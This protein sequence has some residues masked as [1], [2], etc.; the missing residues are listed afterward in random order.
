MA[1]ARP[2]FVDI[3]ERSFTMDVGQLEARVT[4]RTR[5]IIPVHLYGQA[6][7]MD[8]ILEI[9]RRHN[10]YVIEDAA[11]A[12]G[13]EYKR[14]RA[15]SLGHIAGF[16]FYF[17]K[18]LGAYGE[19]GAI[20]TSD[21]RLAERV[22]LLRDHGSKVR[23]QH[24]LYGWNSRLDEVQAAV[25]RV[26]LRYLERWNEQRISHAARYSDLLH[27]SGLRLPLVMPERKHVYY[28][29]VVRSPERDQLQRA[30]AE[31]GVAT[32]I[33]FP[34]PIHLQPACDD[35]GYRE[36]DFPVTEQIAREVLSL[37]MYPELSTDQIRYVAESIAAT[38]ASRDA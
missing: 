23:Y 5:A 14:R 29:Y 36:G 6:A 26:K 4:P 11:Q 3:D 13:A 9:A 33:H 18:N 12:H 1:G 28:V 16:S 24:R 20:T 22:R 10:I 32:G 17:S 37:P 27:G 15:G 31:R 8:P 25:L 30:L 7:D 21:P 2:V 38:R 34:V 19:S 35:L